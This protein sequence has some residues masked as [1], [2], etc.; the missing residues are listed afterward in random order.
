MIVGG[1][2]LVTQVKPGSNRWLL[3]GKKPVTWRKKIMY[4]LLFYKTS[5]RKLTKMPK[6]SR[7][8]D[9]FCVR[10]LQ[11]ITF[12]CTIAI[13]NFCVHYILQLTTFLC[14]TVIVNFCL[15]YCS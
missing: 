14:T 3:G 8:C 11:E 12:V 6:L 1:K 10:K 13:D 5:M 15:H 7:S 4:F 9:S 2:N